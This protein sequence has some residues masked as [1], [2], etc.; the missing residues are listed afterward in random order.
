ML[1]NGEKNPIGRTFFGAQPE[2]AENFKG[3]TFA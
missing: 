3:P 1:S 2:S